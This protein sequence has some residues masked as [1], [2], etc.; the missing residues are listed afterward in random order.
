M[1]GH[2]R[3]RGKFGIATNKTLKYMDNGGS[4][5]FSQRDYREP[6]SMYHDGVEIK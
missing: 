1:K 6:P 2:Q 3:T 4:V 5:F